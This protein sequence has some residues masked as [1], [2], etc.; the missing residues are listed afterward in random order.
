MNRTRLLPLALALAWCTAAA[1]A[2][3]VSGR[4]S[5]AFYAWEQFD[6]VGTSQQFLRA[7]QTAQLTVAQ[8]DVSLTTFLQGTT[9]LAGTFGQAGRVRFYNLYLSWANIGKAVD[10]HLGVGVFAGVGVGTIDALSP[11]GCSTKGNCD[12]IRRG[13]RRAEFAWWKTTCMTI[14]STAGRW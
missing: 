14:S 12:G 7:Y 11:G 2:Q 5:T 6:T 13:H 4:L 9:N 3:F 1:P 10:L 8:G